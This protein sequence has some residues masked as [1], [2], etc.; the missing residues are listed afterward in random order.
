MGHDDDLVKSILAKYPDGA[1]EAAK[2]GDPGELI[3]KL[4]AGVDLSA[5]ER[6]F[7]VEMLTAL[8]SRRRFL[9]D[10]E[11]ELTC[12]V[13]ICDRRGE[14]REATVQAAMQKFGISR[15]SVMRV[16]SAS[17]DNGEAMAWR[18]MIIKSERFKG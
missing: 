18:E 4:E 16:L 2:N 14:K 5:V 7:L 11:I 15:A 6:E 1:V 3:S 9:Y 17:K 10:R 8:N 12:F 13:S